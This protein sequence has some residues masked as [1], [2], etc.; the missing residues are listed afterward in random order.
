MT[1][2]LSFI[3][4]QSGVWRVSFT[5]LLQ[6]FFGPVGVLFVME[7]LKDEWYI[8]IKAY[9][10]TIFEISR[11]ILYY[12]ILCICQIYTSGKVKYT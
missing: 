9:K 12:H 8:V 5:V 3:R 4:E 10:S 7:T 6:C 2:N 1:A 11:G